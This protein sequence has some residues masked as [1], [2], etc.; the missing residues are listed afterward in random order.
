SKLRADRSVPVSARYPRTS[1]TFE[2]QMSERLAEL[3][4]AA[5][6]VEDGRRVPEH[7]LEQ[8]ELTAFAAGP[9]GR[10]GTA[11]SSSAAWPSTPRSLTM[12]IIL[13]TMPCCDIRRVGVFPRCMTS[14]QC[15]S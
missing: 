8:L 6:A 9:A 4:S 14:F 3:I 2:S 11:R 13:A 1:T 10:N 15:L 7:I 12:T 5:E